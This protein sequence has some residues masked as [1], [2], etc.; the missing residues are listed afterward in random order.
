MCCWLR[1]LCR[2]RASAP[3]GGD[4]VGAAA[5]G[6]KFPCLVAAAAGADSSGR[7]ALEIMEA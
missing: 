1:I 6:A 3:G 4:W 7:A 2:A 5:P